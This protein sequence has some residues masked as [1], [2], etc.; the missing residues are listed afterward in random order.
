MC[1]NVKKLTSSQKKNKGEWE[2][3]TEIYI[4][5]IKKQYKS[6]SDLSSGLE[7]DN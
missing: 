7:Q 1:W 4:K 5:K 3:I 6:C 2:E